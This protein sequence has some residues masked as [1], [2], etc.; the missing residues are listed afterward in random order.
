LKEHVEGMLM[1]V[2]V[3]LQAADMEK[4]QLRQEVQRRGIVA[5][6]L[7][8]C[9]TRSYQGVNDAFLSLE[10]V[11]IELSSVINEQDLRCIDSQDAYHRISQDRN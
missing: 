10:K 9:I 8:S 2:R 5:D 3:E 6:Y 7:G 1:Q 11:K 4:Q